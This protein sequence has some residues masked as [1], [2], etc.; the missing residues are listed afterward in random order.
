MPLDGVWPWY[1]QTADIHSKSICKQPAD[2]EYWNVSKIL[3]GFVNKESNHKYNYKQTAEL[4]Y[5]D[6]N[7]LLNSKSN[8]KQ[9]ADVGYW[10]EN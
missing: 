5:L 1:K 8:C 7:T 6:V 2:I 3:N 4:E 10:N 9:T